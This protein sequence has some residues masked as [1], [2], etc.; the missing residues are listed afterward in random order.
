MTRAQKIGVI[1][2]L[3]LVAAL[4][5]LRAS[6]PSALR[7]AREATFDEYQRLSPR[8][9]EAM[10]V[11]VVDIDEQS[12]AEFGQWPWPRDRVAQLIDAVAD[13]GAAAI[14][15]DF[16]FAEPDRLSPRNV[17]A[18]VPGIEPKAA[19]TLPDNDAILARSIAERPVVLGFGLSNNGHHLPPVKASATHPSSS[20]RL[21]QLRTLK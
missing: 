13:A 9:Y 4:T 18:N 15:F 17:V 1:L 3:S 11:R 16:I 19:A 7:L 14:A 6:D 12:L 20:Q 10:P 21:V 8:P 2:G 5:W